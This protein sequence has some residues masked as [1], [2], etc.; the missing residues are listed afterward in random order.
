MQQVGRVVLS[1]RGR[2]SHRLQ[3]CG[4]L[5]LAAQ[6]C[7]W[8]LERASVQLW[9][10]V[11]LVVLWRGGLV[12]CGAVVMSGLGVLWA[13]RSAY[14]VKMACCALVQVRELGELAQKLLEGARRG[15]GLE[16][17]PECSVQQLTDPRASLGRA[18]LVCWPVAAEAVAPGQGECEEHRLLWDVGQGAR[19]TFLR[20]EI[21]R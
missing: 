1:V 20:L 17:A 19:R 16:P 9:C 13:W 21:V 6:Q 3:R 4:A 11:V 8:L 14:G 5:R 15:W 2:D 10:C 18:C 12:R 7:S